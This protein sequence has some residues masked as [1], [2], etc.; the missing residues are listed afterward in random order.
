[1]G[2]VG[3]TSLWVEGGRMNGSAPVGE[4][5]LFEGMVRRSR[6]WNFIYACQGGGGL[7][8]TLVCGMCCVL[9]C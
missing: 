6:P 9:C 4:A 1:M 5:W 3:I 8:F 7:A 2:R